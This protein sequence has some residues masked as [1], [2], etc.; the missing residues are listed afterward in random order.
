MRLDNMGLAAARLEPTIELCSDR[1]SE[2][3]TLPARNEANPGLKR[4]FGP[5]TLTELDYIMRRSHHDK[6]VVSEFDRFNGGGFSNPGCCAT[7]CQLDG[8]RDDIR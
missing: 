7:R 4:L 6:N 2:Y 3:R 5:T 1:L 8:R